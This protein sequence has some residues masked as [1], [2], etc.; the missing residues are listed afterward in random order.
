MGFEVYLFL[1]QVDVDDSDGFTED[2]VTALDDVWDDIFDAAE[3]REDDGL[4]R[5]LFTKLNEYVTD[6]TIRE[7]AYSDD[8]G[9]E[10]Y[11]LQ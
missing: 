7:R 5:L 1:T 10:V 6:E 3:E 11:Y 9:D 4:F 8:M 2:M